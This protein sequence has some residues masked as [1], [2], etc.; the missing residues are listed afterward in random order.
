M[1]AWQN[2]TMRRRSKR[3]AIAPAGIAT[4]SSGRVGAATMRP[5]HSAEPV[6]SSMSQAAATVWSREPRLETTDAAHRLR[7]SR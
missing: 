1:R 5:T 7:N 3:S 4:T 6:S 2:R